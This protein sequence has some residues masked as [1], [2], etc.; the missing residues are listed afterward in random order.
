MCFINPY[1][2]YNRRVFIIAM[3]LILQISHWWILCGCSISFLGLSSQSSMYWGAETTEKYFLMVLKAWRSEMKGSAGL[4]SPEASSSFPDAPSC[5]LFTWAWI[6][7]VSLCTLMFYSH[8]DTYQIE[9]GQTL[10]ASLQLN[11][12]FLKPKSKYNYILRY[13]NQAGPYG[14]YSQEPLGLQ[15]EQASQS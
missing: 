7:G 15:R 4:V 9:L 6:P 12:V 13:W 14:K 5:C 1:V 11:Y 3:C 10:M 8:R 2:S